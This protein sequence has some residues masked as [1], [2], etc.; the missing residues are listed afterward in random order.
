[1]AGGTE[2]SIETI[3][4]MRVLGRTGKNQNRWGRENQLFTLAHSCPCFP[5]DTADF[6]IDGLTSRRA[7]GAGFYRSHTRRPD[8]I[9]RKT[10]VN[11]GPQRMVHPVNLQPATE[12]HRYHIAWDPSAGSTARSRT[13]KPPSLCNSNSKRPFGETKHWFAPSTPVQPVPVPTSQLGRV[14][15]IGCGGGPGNPFGIVML[16]LHTGL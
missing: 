3:T 13:T 9:S 14:G 15:G 4:R 8:P 5:L 16:L 6:L 1:M 10:G 2:C 11:L 12:A 7:S